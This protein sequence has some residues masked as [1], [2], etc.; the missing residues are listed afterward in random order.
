MQIKFLLVFV[1]FSV[2]IINA[3]NILAIFPMEF[4]SHFFI[5]R[6]IVQTL[7]D[8]GH[9]ITMISPYKFDYKNI[10]NVI[11]DSNDRGWK[12]LFID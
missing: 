8:R 1:L 4:K 6:S 12:F 9:N 5:G 11:L 3:S 7:A 2:K 10:E